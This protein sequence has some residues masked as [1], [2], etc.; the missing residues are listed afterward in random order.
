MA[1]PSE[2]LAQSLQVLKE[3][4]YQGHTAIR[5]RDL[6]RTHRERLVQNGF[7]QEVIKGWYIPARPGEQTGDTTSWYASFWAF[8]ASYLDTRFGRDWCLSPEQSLAL[9]AGNMTVPKQLL[10]RTKK[11]TNNLTALPHGTSLLDIRAELP[12]PTDTLTHEGLRLYTLPTALIACAPGAFTQNPT[13][14]RAA[15]SM[16]ADGSDLVWVPAALIPWVIAIRRYGS[17]PG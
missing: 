9:Q 1:T 2:K 6:S 10:V 8:C 3:L 16:V 13:D 5:S 17:C 7:L 4:Q 12:S 11:D 15:L 14:I